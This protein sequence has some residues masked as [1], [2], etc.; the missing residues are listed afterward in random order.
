M[1]TGA[2]LSLEDLV[3][4]LAG[5]SGCPED[6]EQGTETPSQAPSQSSQPGPVKCRHWGSGLSSVCLVGL[7]PWRVSRC[8]LEVT[9]PTY[10]GLPCAPHSAER[11]AY[12]GLDAH[13]SDG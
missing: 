1:S 2:I 12:A 9:F 4:I 10:G 13:T 5:L 7:A 11:D 8:L 3:L 6:E